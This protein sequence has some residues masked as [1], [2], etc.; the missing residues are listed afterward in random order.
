MEK[1]DILSPEYY[2]NLSFPMRLS[3]LYADLKVSGKKTFYN[4]VKVEGNGYTLNS[5]RGAQRLGDKI[6]L[7]ALQLALF[8]NIYLDTGEPTMIEFVLEDGPC[9]GQWDHELISKTQINMS[10]DTDGHKYCTEVLSRLRK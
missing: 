9:K 10:G 6:K 4:E 7:N 3:L 2:E 5:H 8:T 1:Y